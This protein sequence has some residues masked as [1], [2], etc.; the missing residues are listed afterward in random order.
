MHPG[1]ADALGEGGVGERRAGGGAPAGE[2]R[3]RL[4]RPA[5]A[6]EAD[7]GAAVAGADQQAA[8]GDAVE[9]LGVALDMQDD[10]QQV[11]AFRALVRGPERGFQVDGRDQRDVAGGEA[12]LR[13][14]VGIEQPG[15]HPGARVGDPQDAAAVGGLRGLR[16]E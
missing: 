13:E 11:G 15:V 16:D 6:Q 3:V 10:G 1:Q 9:A 2:G 7:E 12:V 5:L 8:G 4:L 14:A